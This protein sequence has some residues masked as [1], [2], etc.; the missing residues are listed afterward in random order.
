MNV[1]PKSL[2]QLVAMFLAGFVLSTGCNRPAAD[3]AAA[4]KNV[5]IITSANFQSEVLSSKEPVLVDF[6]AVWC[7]PCK[8]I[9]PIVSQLAD[10]FEG[11]ARDRKSVV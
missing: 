8:A 10:E 9:A 3:S 6:W 11:R 7:G 2:T 4:S 1:M 5:H